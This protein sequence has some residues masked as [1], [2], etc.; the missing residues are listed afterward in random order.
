MY[1]LLKLELQK[2]CYPE[3]GAGA[4]QDWT[5]CTTLAVASFTNVDLNNE[6][7][8]PASVEYV[9]ATNDDSRMTV[10]RCSASWPEDG[11]AELLYVKRRVALNTP[12]ETK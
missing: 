9:R 1:F 2:F 7:Q 5:G 12:I 11:L 8:H 10:Y 3:P 6:Q 4:G